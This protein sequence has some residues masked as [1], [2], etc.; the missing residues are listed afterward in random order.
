MAGRALMGLDGRGSSASSRGSV[1]P[2]ELQ[3]T[4]EWVARAIG[5]TVRSGGSAAEFG[6]VSID[7]RTIAAGD[8]FVAIRGERFDGADFAGAAID[9][10]AAGVVVERGRELPAAGMPAQRPAVIEV[11]DTTAALQALA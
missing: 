6:D 11:D 9:R 3:L 10:G 8:L 5:G 4:T 7:T 1:P 2:A